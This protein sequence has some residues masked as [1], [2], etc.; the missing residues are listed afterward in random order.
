[1]EFSEYYV[2]FLRKGPAWTAKSSPELDALQARHLAHLD[3]LRAA[4]RLALAGPVEVHSESDLRGISIFP[5][6]KVGSLAVLKDLV[7]GDP[8]F[9]TGRLVA[10]Y[11]TWFVPA[12]DRVG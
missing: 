4:G 12:N 7:E 8:M 9:K 11:A 1:M 5:K 2:V 3:A 6:S 10:E